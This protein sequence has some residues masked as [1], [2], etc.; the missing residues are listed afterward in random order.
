MKFRVQF[1]VLNLGLKTVRF[2]FS[3]YF[4]LIKVGTDIK[5]TFPTHTFEVTL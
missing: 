3:I 2:L 1:R 4:Y 5:L